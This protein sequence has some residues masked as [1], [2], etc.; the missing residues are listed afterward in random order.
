MCD[1]ATN[2]IIFASFAVLPQPRPWT[3][4]TCRERTSVAEGTGKSCHG[5]QQYVTSPSHQTCCNYDKGYQLK[6]NVL[7]GQSFLGDFEWK[8]W[9]RTGGTARPVGGMKS[10]SY[11]GVSESV[12]IATRSTFALLSAAAMVGQTR[13]IRKSTHHER[14]ALHRSR[15]LLSG[16]SESRESRVL[17]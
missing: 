11:T 7:R 5:P 15:D 12:T 14:T 8:A 6:G 1:P 4:H 2:S 3:R 16:G 13:K 17:S 9:M 10:Y